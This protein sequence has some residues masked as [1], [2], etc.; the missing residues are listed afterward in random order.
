MHDNAFGISIPNAS[1]AN[2]HKIANEQLRDFD[3]GENVYSVDFER[4]AYSNDL[5]DIIY[6]LAQYVNV[7]G[8]QC[9]EPLIAVKNLVV[10]QNEIQYIGRNRDTIKIEK[11]GVVY[12]KFLAREWIEK[13]T[14]YGNEI[15]I[16][17]IGT[18]NIN[19]WMGNITP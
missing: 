13:L 2:F 5:K 4:D 6:D 7:W 16:T 14:Q 19:E 1:L 18:A 3:F 15:R 11:N 9:S 12:I 8:Q 10:R 17:I